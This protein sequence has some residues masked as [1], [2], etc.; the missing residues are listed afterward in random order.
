MTTTTADSR[1]ILELL[2]QGAITVDEADQL[3]RAVSAAAS[4]AGPSAASAGEARREASRWLRITVDK[5]A[6]EGRAP[7]QVSIRV[8]MA[9]VRG[10]ARLGAM[11][12]RVAGDRVAEKLRE[13]GIDIAA[14][15][16]SQIEQLL[17]SLGETTIDLDEGQGKAHVRITCE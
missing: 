14:I 9:V 4:A 3:L 17:E 10:G 1:R 8:P 5:P 11:F 7:K 13:Q 16:F 15:D 2:A 6:R 12:P